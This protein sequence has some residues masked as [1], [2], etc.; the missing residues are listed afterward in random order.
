MIFIIIMTIL[1]Y[2]IL[3]AWTWES[4]SFMERP[5]KVAYLVIGFIIMYIITFILF[6]ITK[7]GIQYENEQM[8]SDVQNILVLL[9]TGINGIIIMPQV[10]KILDKINDG[11]KEKRSKKIS[12]NSNYIY[13]LLNNRKWLHEKY[14]RRNFKYI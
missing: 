12:N 5:K 1:T 4:L 7:S 13:Y 9:F 6:Q 14:S 10:A 8:Q 3:I 11:E 2:F